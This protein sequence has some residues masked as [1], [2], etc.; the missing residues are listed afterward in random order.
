MLAYVSVI[1]PTYNDNKRLAQCLEALGKQT[2]PQEKCE[3][4]VVDN[5]SDVSPAD[6]VAKYKNARLVHEEKAGSYTARNKGIA[7][8]KGDIFAF[9]DADCIPDTTWL[10]NGVVH[11][12]ADD[13]VCVIGGRTDI[14]YS[15]P[16]K[17]T[18][19]EL[20]EKLYAFPTERNIRLHH[21]APTCNLFT[22]RATIDAIGL[23]NDTLKSG[24]DLEWGQRAYNAG[25]A[26]QYADDAIVKHPARSTWAQLAK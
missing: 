19:V 7:V 17:P 25:V 12:E 3:I 26:L 5:G 10:E 18:S 6:L 14:F 13:D 1:I 4:I 15:H 20:Y 8:A 23:F 22:T 2:Y 21:Y 9:T 11:I 24:G 16:S